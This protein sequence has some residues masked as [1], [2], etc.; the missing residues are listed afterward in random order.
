MGLGTFIFWMLTLKLGMGMDK[1]EAKTKID[2]LVKEA[3]A[4]ITEAEELSEQSGLEFYFS[5]A[6]GM[7]GTYYPENNAWEVSPGWSASS[8]SC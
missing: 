8:Q 1:A 4:K 3:Y 5:P 6:Y 2:E 7:G